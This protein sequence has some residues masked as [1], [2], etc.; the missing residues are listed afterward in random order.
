[1]VGPRKE[2]LGVIKIKEEED[3]ITNVFS[4][5]GEKHVGINNATTGR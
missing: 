5:E 1:M 2:E 4:C 3:G